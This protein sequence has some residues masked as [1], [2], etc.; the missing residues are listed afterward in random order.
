MTSTSIIG[1]G[2]ARNNMVQVFR[3]LAITAVVII[4]TTPL[5][6]CQVFCRPFINF[7]VATFL[8]LSG[9]L[10][11]V[12][13]E[14]WWL[15]YKK[16]IIRVTIPYVIWTVLYTLA[17]RHIGKLPVNLLTAK[18]ATPMYYIFVYIQFVIF[19]PLLGKLA[20]SRYQFLG[21]IIAPVSVIIFKYYW[22]LTGTPLN[23]YISIFWSDSCLGWVTFY[24][25]GLILGNR[26]IEK[27]FSIKILTILYLVSIVLQIAEGYGWLM[28]GET[29]CGTQLKLTSIL[30]SSLFLLIIHSTL[31]SSNFDIKNHFFRLLGDYSFGIY[32]CHMMVIKVLIYLLPCNQTIPYPITSAIVLLLSLCCC[33]IG[34][35]ICGE[36]ISK[37]LGLQ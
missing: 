26:I 35:K 15:F 11:K 27:Q 22:L 13:N 16:R 17:S 9:Y 14:N 1:G 5:G 21:W 6:N 33:Y 12:D 2:K 25:L 18:A 36:R 3:A 34:T 29:N 30:T 37:W 7:S 31:H 8:F 24:Y 23:P 28:L 4:H 32:L 10:T 19:T 20:K